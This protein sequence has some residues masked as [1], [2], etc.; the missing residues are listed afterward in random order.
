M[1]HEKVEGVHMG[2]HPLV[3]RLMKGV[4]N[5]RPLKPRYTYTWDVD[6]VIQYIAGMGDNASLPLKRLSQKLALLMALAVASRT[7]ELQALDLRSRIYRPNG[8]LFRQQALPRHRELGHH[9]KS[10]FFGAFS[11]KLLCVVEC[12]KCYEAMTA[13]HRD[14]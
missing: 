13:K 9:Q 5:L 1:T 11:D 7:S 12:L 4:Y 10:V 14:M 2:Q 6:M 3:T 8:E